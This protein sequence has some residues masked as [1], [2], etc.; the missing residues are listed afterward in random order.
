MKIAFHSNQL[1]IR[2]TET[3]MF[4]YAELNEELLGNSSIIIT[5]RDSALHDEHA[6]EKFASRFSVYGYSNLDDLE[7]TLRNN[8]VDL[9]YCIKSGQNDG[10]ISKK[11]KTVVHSVFG[12]CE[13]HG[14]VYAYVSQWLA[15]S[16]SQGRF[17][18]VPH[19]VRDIPACGNLRAELGIPEDAIVFGRHGGP[20]TFDLRFVHT[21][22]EALV[23]RR[24]DLYFLFLH[25]N[26][27]CEEHPQIIHLPATCKTAD[28]SK[29]IATCDAMIH[30]RDSGETFG[31]AVAE[32]SVMNKPIITFDGSHERAHIEILG[33]K[34]LFYNDIESLTKIL[35]TFEP[36]PDQDWR[37]YRKQFPAEVVMKKF[38]DVFIAG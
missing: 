9:L 21:I 4:D 36:Q 2:G 29:F 34:A 25:T 30:A 16:A 1:S 18:F 33:N 37:V 5:P 6:A 23:K 11:I 24:S 13:P 15:N 32:F 35:W 14:D 27:F 10:I 12:F 19:V 7:L 26:K 28:K 8:H 31:L 17:A 38:H 22:I 3:A 20:D